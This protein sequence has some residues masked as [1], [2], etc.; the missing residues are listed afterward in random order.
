MDTTSKFAGLPYP[1]RNLRKSSG[2]EL[3]IIA[4]NRVVL[5]S[6]LSFKM[7]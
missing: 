3:F 4:P 5:P 1:T 6:V 7:R 2:P